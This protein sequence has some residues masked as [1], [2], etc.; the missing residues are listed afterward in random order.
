MAVWA[1]LRVSTQRQADEGISID[2]QEHQISAYAKLHGLTVTDWVRDRGVSGSV[3]LSER[4]S[5]KKILERAIKG[6]VIICAKLD[7]MFRS[8]RN[9]LEVL[10]QLKSRGVSLHCID[11]GGDVCNGIGQLVFTIL[12]AVAEQER[13]RL[14]ERI[15]EAKSKMRLENRYQ[16][17][18]IPFGYRVTSDGILVIDE[19]QQSYIRLIREKRQRNWSLRKISSFLSE[20]LQVNLSHNAIRHILAGH[21]KFENIVEVTR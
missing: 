14:R 18:K 2:V 17:G 5:G 8:A 10:D 9:A 11:L 4:D 3:P 20:E 16:G 15:S 6:D 12:S 21:R 1:Y 13:T 7:R 19:T